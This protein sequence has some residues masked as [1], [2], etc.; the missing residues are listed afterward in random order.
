ME[1]EFDKSANPQRPV[2]FDRMKLRSLRMAEKLSLS[3]AMA[4]SSKLFVFESN[5]LLSVERTRFLPRE[6]AKEGQIRCSK[7]ELNMLIGQ[8]FVEQT[9]VNLFSSILDTPDFLWD[10][11][12]FVP[13]YQYTRSYLEVDDRV[14]LLN[15]RLAVIRELLDVLTAQVANNNSTR[16]EWIIIWL[17]TVETTIGIAT[18]PL[19]EGYRIFAMVLVPTAILLYSRYRS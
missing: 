10:D 4:Q 16:L 15:S 19:F 12:E 18:N 1:Y 5:V 9:E 17:I 11:D 6:L 13:V 3:Y 7:K 2:R 8:L 14:A